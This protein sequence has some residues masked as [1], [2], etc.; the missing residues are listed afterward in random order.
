[1][2]EIWKPIPGFSKYQVSNLGRVK[3]H[4]GLNWR[5]LKP[6]PSLKGYLFVSLPGKRFSAHRLV[7]S[8]FLKGHDPSKNEVNHLNFDR[9]DNRASNLEWVSHRENLRYSMKAG[10]MSVSKKN[11]KQGYQNIRWVPEVAK[12]RV[13]IGFDRKQYNVGY[14][15]TIDEAIIA[16]N[17][18][19][20]ELFTQ[21][22][23]HDS[24]T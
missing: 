16:R 17:K 9:K 22:V 6:F 2:N 12:F 5:I 18:K 11:S 4:A 24:S 14:F 23:Q 15:E 10:H 20:Q 1:M 21:E 13:I 3:S 8:L 19:R 7:A